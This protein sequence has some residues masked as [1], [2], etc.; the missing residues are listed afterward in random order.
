MIKLKIIKKVNLL[1]RM[2]IFFI[3]EN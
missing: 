2:T 3:K 1:I